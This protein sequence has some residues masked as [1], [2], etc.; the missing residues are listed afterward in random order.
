[1]KAT[2][3]ALFWQHIK[4]TK[5]WKSVCNIENEAS[6]GTFGSQVTD[7]KSWETCFMSYNIRSF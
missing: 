2:G 7:L 1:M 3:T 5:Y 6:K 4:G